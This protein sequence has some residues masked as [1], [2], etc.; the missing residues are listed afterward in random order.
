MIIAMFLVN[1][2]HLTVTNIFLV[3]RSFKIYFSRKFQIY[4]SVLLTVLMM[5]Y[6][7]FP[8]HI[9]LTNRSLYLL[10]FL[11]LLNWVKVVK[12]YKFPS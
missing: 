7:V 8:E 4:T 9:Y 10:T 1:V 5:L 3:I 11:H 6:V 2:H 12:R